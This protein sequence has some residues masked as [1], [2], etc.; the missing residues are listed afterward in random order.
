MPTPGLT[1]RSLLG[2]ACAGCAAVVT[3]CGG[4]SSP[5]DAPTASPGA[6]GSLVRLADV[7][8]GGSVSAATPDGQVVLVARTGEATAAAFSS[9]CTHAGCTVAAAG[10]ELRCPCHGSVFKA[11]D[12]SVLHGPARSPLPP[13]P[14]TV[15][16][17]VVRPA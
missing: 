4:G 9:R 7:P 1:R 11:S 5:A 2:A 14:V 10:G 12:G 16:D 13:Y 6:D 3:G 8:V 17:G 15:V